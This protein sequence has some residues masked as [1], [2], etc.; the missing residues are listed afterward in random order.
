MAQCAGSLVQGPA[1][2]GYGI[3]HLLR[4]ERD[5]C[6]VDHQWTMMS[7]SL[8]LC[9][10]GRGLARDATIS[11]A[12]VGLGQKCWLRD[13]GRLGSRAI[14]TG[15]LVPA[16]KYRVWSLRNK[17]AHGPLRFSE[18]GSAERAQPSQCLKGAPKD[19]FCSDQSGASTVRLQ[20]G[21]R[22]SYVVTHRFRAASSLVAP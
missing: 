2:R 12:A 22:D 21:I 10:R 19:L 20:I 18:G 13:L 4:M 17:K 8:G 16:L 7:I 5:W 9:S 15:V 3:S 14:P 6:S 11:G 1:S